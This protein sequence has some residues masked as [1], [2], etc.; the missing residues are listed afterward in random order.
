MDKARRSKGALGVILF[1]GLCLVLFPGSA[2]K[3]QA[4]DI[5]KIGVPAPMT[6]P[7]AETGKGMKGATEI[8]VA[9]INAAGGI[10]GKKIKVFYGDDESKAAAG[11]SVVERMINRD[12]VD[13]IIGTMNS[14]VGLATME[15]TANYRV[16]FILTCPASQKITDKIKANQERYK[17]LVKSDPTTTAH[18]VGVAAAADFL[19]KKDPANTKN[20]TAFLLTEHNEWGKSIAIAAVD[21]LNKVGWKVIDKQVHDI[22]ETNFMAM[23]SK[24]KAKNPDILV[25]A[26]T[27]A[28]AAASLARQFIEQGLQIYIVQIYGALKPGYLEALGDKGEGV[29]AEI[30]V[31]C[32]TGECDKFTKKFVEKYGAPEFD[33][34]GNMQY[35]MMLMAKV[36]YE[37]AGS[38]DK[39]KF[40]KEFL[41]MKHSGTVGVYEYVPDTHESKVGKDYIPTIVRQ[42]Q[43]GKWEFLLPD[44]MR[45]TK[46]M[47]PSWMK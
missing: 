27:S 31:D 4:A 21:E 34:C 19:A 17:Y 29:I 15:I 42:L 47:K 35:D 16:P 5:L 7:C 36:A 2:L 38:F 12:K 9:E 30:M 26:E 1:A 6:G 43:K 33:V 25:T 8:A 24:I 32:H 46:L 23:I 20:K 39:D 45:K 41:A 40:I 11:A 13:I 18:A 44:Y 22:G 28:S 37:K 14:N 3:G 10:L